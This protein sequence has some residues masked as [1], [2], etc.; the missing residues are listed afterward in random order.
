MSDIAVGDTIHHTYVPPGLLDVTVLA[1]KPCEGDGG[2]GDHPSYLIKDP[3]SGEPDWVCS[4][5]FVKVPVA[6]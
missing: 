1:V 6:S 3:E 5:D 4:R 2:E